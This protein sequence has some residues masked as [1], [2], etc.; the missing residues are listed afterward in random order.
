MHENR[1]PFRAILICNN[2]EIMDMNR[3]NYHNTNLAQPQ[4]RSIMEYFVH[5]RFFIFSSFFHLQYVYELTHAKY[6]DIYEYQFVDHQF[7]Y[8]C[9]R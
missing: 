7:F 2:W 3:Q 4:Q 8:I 5:V 1:L 6:A 9:I